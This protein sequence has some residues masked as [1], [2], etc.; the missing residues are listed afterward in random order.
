MHSI[1]PLVS[2]VVSVAVLGCTLLGALVS[3][4]AEPPVLKVEGQPLAAQVKRVLDGLEMLGTPLPAEALKE[5]Q[6]ALE[7]KD[8]TRIQ[9]ILDQH[10]L[11]VVDDNGDGKVTATSGPARPVLQQGGFIPA[12][13]KV[14]NRPGKRDR[15]WIQSPQAGAVYAGASRFSLERQQQTELNVW[16]K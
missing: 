12:L 5:L 10:V 6:P 13:V 3:A 1:S 14:L 16:E 7:A 15:L 2:R 9:K 11:F 4:A 8:V